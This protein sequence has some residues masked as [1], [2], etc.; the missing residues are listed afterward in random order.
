MRNHSSLPASS[1]QELEEL[2]ES[3]GRG[4]LSIERLFHSFCLP[5]LEEAGRGQSNAPF[6]VPFSR[7]LAHRTECDAGRQF[8][9]PFVSSLRRRCCGCRE[10]ERD[11][12]SMRVHGQT[13]RGVIFKDPDMPLSTSP[14]INDTLHAYRP[15]SG[16]GSSYSVE[17]RC[18]VPEIFAGK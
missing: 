16:T 4:R 9:S 8:D 5:V 10:L 18:T 3:F 6:S 2:K 11:R 1:S 12:Y 15:R 17:I 13:Q 7:F 14:A